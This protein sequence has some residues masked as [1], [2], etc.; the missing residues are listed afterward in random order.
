PRMAS[1][2][3]GGN[4]SILHT[5]S[6]QVA[7]R[8]ILRALSTGLL[9]GDHLA[10]FRRSTLGPD[11]GS[12]GRLHLARNLTL[13]YPV[14]DIGIGGD[15]RIRVDLGLA[16]LVRAHGGDVKPRMQPFGPDQRLA[17]GRGGDDKL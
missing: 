16:R 13:T 11:S 10:Q 6:G 8:H 2:D 15:K 7:D 4:G 14:T 5:R 12:Q 3:M 1:A 9:T 17:R